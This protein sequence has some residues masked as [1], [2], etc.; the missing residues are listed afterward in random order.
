M[1]PTSLVVDDAAA[2]SKNFVSDGPKS[3]VL[4]FINSETNRPTK[5]QRVIPRQNTHHFCIKM[6]KT[7]IFGV[8]FVELCTFIILDVPPSLKPQR[9]SY[10]I[11]VMVRWIAYQWC[12]IPFVVA[13]TLGKTW[14]TQDDTWESDLLMLLRLVTLIYYCLYFLRIME[15]NYSFSSPVS[16][17]TSIASFKIFNAVKQNIRV[18]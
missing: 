17:T 7:T 13:I 16:P 14:E 9:T 11:Q 12:H 8:Y 3:F 1:K 2:H 6:S 10:C 4:F 5:V 18:S 15:H